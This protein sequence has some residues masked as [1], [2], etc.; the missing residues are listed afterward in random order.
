MK[1]IVWLAL[2]LALFGCSKESEVVKPQ[3]AERSAAQP[4]AEVRPDLAAPKATLPEIVEQSVETIVP[5]VEANAADMETAEE[6]EA[7]IAA[8]KARAIELERAN[9]ERMAKKL[10]V[11]AE[12]YSNLSI[13][14][15][16]ELIRKH[17]GTK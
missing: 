6:T 5:I 13:E 14:K 8:E 1:H 2:A 4:I 7:R 17:R 12:E 16:R 9:N 11:S 10:G 3:I 15:Q